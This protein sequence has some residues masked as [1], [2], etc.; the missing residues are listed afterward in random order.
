MNRLSELFNIIKKSTFIIYMF[1]LTKRIINIYLKIA[2][3]AFLLFLIFL[4]FI[5]FFAPITII[6]V[7]NNYIYLLL[8]LIS[9]LIWSIN[10]VFVGFAY[11]FIF[12]RK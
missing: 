5:M 4:S 10:I 7:T 3:G 12:E 11:W 9:F 6:H 1:N 8:Y 2:V